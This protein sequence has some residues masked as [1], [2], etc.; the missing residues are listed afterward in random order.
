LSEGKTPCLA[1][2]RLPGLKAV[3]PDPEREAPHAEATT[4]ARPI[5]PGA[6]RQGPL[7]TLGLRTGRPRPRFRPTADMRPAGRSGGCRRSREPA[8]S[9]LRIS[10][11]APP[12]ECMQRRLAPRSGSS[13]DRFASRA[14]ALRDLQRK[15]GRRRGTHDMP[16][17]IHP[18]GSSPAVR[19][20]R[21]ARY[22]RRP[23][24]PPGQGGRGS[25]RRECVQ[26]QSAGPA[27]ADAA[28]QD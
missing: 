6:R 26:R 22:A 4:D 28:G 10:P 27:R 1:R 13:V 15:A 14:P 12:P 21:P 5:R 20:G 23:T 24:A 7:Q 16:R 2:R 19:F 18:T 17:A 3:R 25:G 11:R 8:S 9:G